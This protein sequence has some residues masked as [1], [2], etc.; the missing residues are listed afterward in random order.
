MALTTPPSLAT[1]FAFIVQGHRYTADL[2]PWFNRQHIG[3]A[4]A[5]TFRRGYDSVG[6]CALNFTIGLDNRA[7]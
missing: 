2:K 6:S 3:I 4:K 7:S 1:P 5:V